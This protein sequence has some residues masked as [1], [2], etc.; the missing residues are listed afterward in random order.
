MSNEAEACPDCKRTEAKLTIFEAQAIGGQGR[1]E[2][3]TCYRT[4]VDRPAEAPAEP[5][6][7][8]SPADLVPVRLAVKPVVEK[9]ATDG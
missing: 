8:L 5:A 1:C 6:P 9:P 4:D 2:C 7:K 3:G